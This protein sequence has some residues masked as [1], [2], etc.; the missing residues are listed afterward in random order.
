MEL[1]GPE[2]RYFNNVVGSEG[3]GQFQ[4][5][6]IGLNTLSAS[7]RVRVQEFDGTH[8]GAD[9]NPNPSKLL[10]KEIQRFL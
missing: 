4:A 5:L 8:D 7:Q 3:V 10:L 1:I 6:A 2:D 9:R